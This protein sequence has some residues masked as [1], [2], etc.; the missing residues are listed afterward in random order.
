[1]WQR[2]TK[3]YKDEEI[4]NMLRQ[5]RNFLEKELHRNLEDLLSHGVKNGSI[6]VNKLDILHLGTLIIHLFPSELDKSEVSAVEKLIGWRRCYTEVAFTSNKTFF[7]QW[8]VLVMNL[9][10][11]AG[12][13]TSEIESRL[14]EKIDYINENEDLE[15]TGECLKEIVENV[16]G[17]KTLSDEYKGKIFIKIVAIQNLTDRRISL[18]ESY[19]DIFLCIMLKYYNYT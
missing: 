14:T 19:P 1:M 18:G 15:E 3:T 6:Q 12:K 5:T 4:W 11:L 13:Q 9:T 2:E 8:T 17:L 7:R 16:R 10:S